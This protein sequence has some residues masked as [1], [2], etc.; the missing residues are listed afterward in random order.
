MANAKIETEALE[1]EK[2]KL[3]V[4]KELEGKIKLDVGGHRFT[5]SLTTL[6]RFP[7]TMLG[8]MFSGRHTFHFDEE[9]Y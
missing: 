6:R 7:D 4:S 3:S 2:A 8:A 1:A 9:G 5:T